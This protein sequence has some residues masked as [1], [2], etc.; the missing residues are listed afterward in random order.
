MNT[1]HQLSDTELLSQTQK[2]VARER[3]LTLEILWHL[4]EVE[5]RRLYSQ[6][7]CSS[8]FEYCTQS[9]CS[10]NFLKVQH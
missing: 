3:E 6:F 2:L 7:A 10:T 5:K 9:E 4:Q 1:L 8:L